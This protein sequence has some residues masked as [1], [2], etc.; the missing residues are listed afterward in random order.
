MK[1]L[2]TFMI[3]F[4]SMSLF[5]QQA[6]PAGST[7]VDT[8]TTV[9]F[10]LKFEETKMACKDGYF[11]N[12]YIVNLSY[13]EAKKLDGKKIK[14]TGVFTI[15]KGLKNQPKEYDEHGNIIY[16]QGRLHDTKFINLPKIEI[17]DE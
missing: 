10:I 17:L 6:K 5:A 1:Q 7:T 14:V 16:Q 3:L 13:E 8:S 15:V 9:S 11:M 12:G 2:L 4:A